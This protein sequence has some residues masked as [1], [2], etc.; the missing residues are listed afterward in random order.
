MIEFDSRKRIILDVI[1][2][3]NTITPRP[4]F[5][6]K[7]MITTSDFWAVLLSKGIYNE[8]QRRMFQRDIRKIIE[9]K[10]II[11]KRGRKPITDDIR[12]F[13]GDALTEK[14][15]KAWNFDMK[16]SVID[17][18]NMQKD[19]EKFGIDWVRHHREKYKHI[20]FE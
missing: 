1:G 15:I 16:L 5:N 17:S 20:Q 10:L 4:K 6:G 11:M 18:Y 12:F 7:P 14:D 13:F 9:E 19:E 8:N 2:S 3:A